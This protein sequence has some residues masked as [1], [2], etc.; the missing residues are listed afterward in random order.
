MTDSMEHH[1]AAQDNS[2]W[3]AHLPGRGCGQRTDRPGPQFAPET[4]ADKLGD[5]AY[6]L[7][8]QAK[9]LRENAPQVDYALRGLIQSERRALPHRCGRMRLKRV[10]RLK[11]SYIRV[12]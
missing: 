2:N 12:V 7:L 1:F 9:H 8:W 5:D 11:W 3:P 6:I 10:V 4:G